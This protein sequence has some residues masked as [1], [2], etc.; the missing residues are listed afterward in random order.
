MGAF[1]SQQLQGA[2]D[3]RYALGSAYLV[4]AALTWAVYALAQ[5]QLLQHL[6]SAQIMWLLY[7]CCG[8]IF[9]LFARPQQL[10]HL[11]GLQWG[12]LLFCGLNTIVA[13][14]A[15][16]E[17]LD[18]WPASQV[19][20]VLALAPIVTMGAMQIAG[21]SLQLH[22]EQLTPLATLGA[23]AVVTGSIAIALG[24]RSGVQS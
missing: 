18:H 7:G 17:S 5:K 12:M 10:V 24:N 3:G 19:S 6:A 21:A 22:P 2:T 23:V 1:F 15:F 8:G 14:G 11:S 4:I 16:A 13:Y 20:A 9:A